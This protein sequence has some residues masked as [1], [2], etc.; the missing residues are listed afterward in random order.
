MKGIQLFAECGIFVQNELECCVMDC[1][2]SK[3]ALRWWRAASGNLTGSPQYA[4]RDEDLSGWWTWL[5]QP[6]YSLVL[7]M[8][9]WKSS[10]F[11]HRLF[12]Y[13]TGHGLVDELLIIMFSESDQTGVITECG[14]GFQ[15]IFHMVF[16]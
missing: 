10:S 4:Q 14:H 1:S 16:L 8:K 15:I 12:K 11:Y 5:V 7:L 13:D 9:T 2:S 3:S 6:L